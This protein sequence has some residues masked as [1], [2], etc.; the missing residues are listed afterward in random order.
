M[1]D[2]LLRQADRVLL[3][4]TRTAGDDSAMALLWGEYRPGSW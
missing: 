3:P 2:A 4:V 1:L